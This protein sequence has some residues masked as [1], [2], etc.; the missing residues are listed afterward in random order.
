MVKNQ[1]ETDNKIVDLVKM[2]I[3]IID[4]IQ[5]QTVE[6]AIFVREY[7]G[8]GFG[9]GLFI[10]HPVPVVDS[11][12]GTAVM[13]L[14]SQS[15]QKIEELSQGLVALKQSFSEGVLLQNAFIST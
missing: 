9:G 7:T 2:M 12:S 5:K 10:S 11:S 8:H 13:R 4:K 14:W 6:C 15:S 1:L 3:D